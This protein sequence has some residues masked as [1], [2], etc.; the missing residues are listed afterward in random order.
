MAANIEQVNDSTW[1]SQVLRS[2]IP[3]LVDFW[4]EWCQPCIRMVPD[5]EAVAE[6]FAGKLKVAKV[7]VQ[8]N[9]RVPDQYAVQNLPTLFVFK[10]GMVVEQRIGKLSKQ[11]LIKLV[12]PYL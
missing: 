4:A 11:D 9:E 3:V 10:G 1:E 8:Q 7:D 2:P 6:Q 5:L 12:Q